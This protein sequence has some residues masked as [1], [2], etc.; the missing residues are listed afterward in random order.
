[1]QL[2]S[3][4][5]A[6][7]SDTGDVVAGIKGL[8]GSELRHSFLRS[9]HIV[10]M[11]AVAITPFAIGAGFVAGGAAIVLGLVLVLALLLAYAINAWMSDISDATAAFMARR[12]RILRT[13]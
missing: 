6:G 11:L 3:A 10:L 2:I 8:L 1:M 5:I 7:G 9:I 12:P 13:V 4:R